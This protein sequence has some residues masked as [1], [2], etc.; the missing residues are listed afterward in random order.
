M[1]TPADLALERA[2]AVAA[3]DRRVE[4]FDLEARVESDG[5][6]LEGVLGTECVRRAVR[7]ELDRTPGVGVV[8]DETV[9]LEGDGEALTV[10]RDA[11]PVRGAPETDA[12]QVTQALYGAALT[13]YDREAG[14]RRVRVSDGYVG[15]VEREHLERPADENGGS[16]TADAVITATPATPLEGGHG[17]PARL[18]AGTGC[19]FEGESDG[20]A[21]VA[22]RTGA[23]ARLPTDAVRSLSEATPAAPVG[24]GEDVVAVARGFLETPY[25]WGGMR[26]DGIDC[27]GLAWVSYATL[28]VVLPRDADQQETVG[29]DVDRDD[30][31]P[32]DLLFFPGHV[33]IS[34]GGSEYVHAYGDADG[35][36]INSLDPDDDRYVESLD[37]SLRTTKRLLE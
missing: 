26:A 18:Q 28:G 31:A 15:W 25:E 33:A 11:V 23:S 1:T 4:P 19:R 9:V 2:A 24:T 8:R 34:L 32:G 10:S 5:V 13:G 20:V 17:T 16:W 35:V 7:R 21:T 22:F 30:L 37:D 3:P 12:E 6:V 29:A 27:S 36:T 14:W